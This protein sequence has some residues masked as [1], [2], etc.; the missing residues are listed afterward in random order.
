M[1][2]RLIE[3]L[4]SPPITEMPQCLLYQ[5]SSAPY[6]EVEAF[7]W[8]T[9]HPDELLAL[10]LQHPEIGPLNEV[11]HGGPTGRYIEEDG[12]QQYLVNLEQTL[13]LIVK[14]DEQPPPVVALTMW[15]RALAGQYRLGL[16]RVDGDLDLS[17]D[18]DMMTAADRGGF[19]PGTPRR[20]RCRGRARGTGWRR[21]AQRGVS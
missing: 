21:Q 17:N 20:K 8:Q 5:M 11:K 14:S 2:R 6:H 15:M 19:L 1:A 18:V 7:H 12:E 9:K 10:Q 13:Y 3:A 16:L 4:G